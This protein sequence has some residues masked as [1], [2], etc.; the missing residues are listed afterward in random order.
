ME[1]CGHFKYLVK[2]S[3]FYGDVFFNYNKK[4]NQFFRNWFC[5]TSVFH[6]FLYCLLQLFEKFGHFLLSTP[7][8][9]I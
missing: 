6:Y 5:V 7:Q 8:S 4:Q 2:M 9:I 1:Y 3:S